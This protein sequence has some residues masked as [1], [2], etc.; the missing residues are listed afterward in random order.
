MKNLV[1]VNDTLVFLEMVKNDRETPDMI[2]SLA[3]TLIN[4]WN[5]EYEKM[6]KMEVED[7]G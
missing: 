5:R 2:R 3:K 1:L 4:S 6:Y 7:N